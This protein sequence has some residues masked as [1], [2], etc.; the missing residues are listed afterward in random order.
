MNDQILSEMLEE[1]KGLRGESIATNQ[2]LDV[3]NQRL[4]GL[5][6]S[7]VVLQQGM[8]EVRYELHGIKEILSERVI[9]RNE[10]ITIETSEGTI[11]QGV[12]NKAQKK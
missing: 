10:T 3:T 7:F 6:E 5:R 12:I 11:I 2:R 9:W 4:E 1:I 8:A